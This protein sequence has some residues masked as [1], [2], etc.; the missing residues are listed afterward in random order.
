MEAQK[1]Y[2][3]QK[4][5]QQMD[6]NRVKEAKRITWLGFYINLFLSLGKILAGWFGKSSAMLADGVHS[7]SDFFTD[8]VVLLFIGISGKEEDKGHSY[9]HGKF[10]TFATLI[11]S[12]V[13]LLVG[14]GICW[15]GIVKIFSSLS[16]E[17]IARPSIVALVF[18]I[19]SIVVK[20]VL[21]RVTIKVGKRI[22]SDAVIANGWHH[23]SDAFSSI[24]TTIGIAGA[25][26]L[27]S[28]W[29]I[30]DPIASI[31]VSVFIVIAGIKIL[32]PAVKELLESSLPDEIEERMTQII[33]STEG[34]R[35]MKNLK[36]RKNGDNYIINVTI[37]VNPTL[38]VVE[39]HD[40]ATGVEQ[41]LNMS[42][43]K[44]IQSSVHVEPY[45]D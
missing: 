36:T 11:I 13:L 37:K 4:I 23:R 34:V 21:F 39:A 40:I 7:L 16:G 3:C 8:A 33:T 12:V 25:I 24:G 18:A 20:E 35:G 5:I 28:K 41:A 43:N 19:I 45:L 2:I 32:I 22:D 1:L 9:G 27:G 31:I 14:F 42:C 26:F 29:R 30:L 17:E 6:N 38:T 15:Q 10:E 44:N